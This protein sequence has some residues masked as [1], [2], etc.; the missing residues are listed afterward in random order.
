MKQIQFGTDGWRDIIADGFDFESVSR[1]AQAHA[2]FIQQSGGSRVVI[3]FDTRF[4]SD[5]FAHR[6]AEVMAAN[7]LETH[8][9]V[10]YVPTPALSFAVVQFKADNGV[11]ITASHNPPSYNG[12]KIKGAYGGSATPATAKAVEAELE[13]LKP[14]PDFDPAVHQIHPFDIR[15]AYTKAVNAILDLEKLKTFSGRMVHNAMG[16]AGCG[17]LEGIVQAAGIN[18]N[19]GL[20]HNEPHPLFYGVNPE[21]IAPNL[22]GFAQTIQ[23]PDPMTFG[24]ATDGDADRLG[25]ILNTGEFFNSHQIFAVLLHHL[26]QKGLRGR[27]VKT[28]STSS[29]IDILADNRGL[30]VLETPVGFKYITEAF[31]EGQSDPTQRVL[32]GGEES[33][34]LAVIGHVPERDGI[35][36]SLLLLEAVASSGKSLGV[37]FAELEREA[38][39]THAY[40]R[41]DLHLAAN[42]DKNAVMESLKHG[43]SIAGRKVTSINTKDGVKWLLEG[44]GWVLFRASGTEPLLRLYAE[45]QTQAEVKELLEAAKAL[46]LGQ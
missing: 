4:A 23:T 19:L 30:E 29:L 12:Y 35:L 9:S 24:I 38:G 44:F 14:I 8:L 1:V 13:R 17:W 25:A 5:R 36:N 42:F 37:L 21:P 34:G 28:V 40:D 10:S 39:V 45:A 2:Q 7:G 3:G 41:Y 27:V 31:L 6:V 22:E 33:G 43:S 32:I 16:G 11:M 46:V 20:Y 26:H 15:E 18:I